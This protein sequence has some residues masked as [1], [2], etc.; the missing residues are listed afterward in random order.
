VDFNTDYKSSEPLKTLLM[1]CF[2]W[3]RWSLR[4]GTF[5]KRRVLFIGISPR[6]TSC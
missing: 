4:W 2:C 6:T 3:L 5:T 1:L